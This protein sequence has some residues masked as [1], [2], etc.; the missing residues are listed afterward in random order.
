MKQRIDEA[1]A[2]IEAALRDTNADYTKAEVEEIERLRD[3]LRERR[4]EDA[5]CALTGQTILTLTER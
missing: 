1:L 5:D 3:A 4:K 2:D